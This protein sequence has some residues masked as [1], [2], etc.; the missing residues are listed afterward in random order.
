MEIVT[1]SGPSAP[2]T[3]TGKIKRI[4]LSGRGPNSGELTLAIG[5]PRTKSENYYAGI[6]DQCGH[7]DGIEHGVFAGFV[8][9]ATLAYSTRATVE[10]TYVVTD[11]ARI[12]G[13]VIA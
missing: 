9:I 5:P 7:P 1:M 12:T 13:L 8:N 4:G 6:I 11:K 3:I 2:Q 10:C